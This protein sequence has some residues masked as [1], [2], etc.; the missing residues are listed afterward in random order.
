MRR[1][2]ELT[3]PFGSCFFRSLEQ[4]HQ[5][6]TER[7]GDSCYGSDAGPLGWEGV[8]VIWRG[9]GRWLCCI[10]SDV[11]K[12]QRGR[13][14][15][16]A[17]V[18]ACFV[19]EHRRRE[20]FELRHLPV[21]NTK[22]TKSQNKNKPS[23]RRRSSCFS[24]APYLWPTPRLDFSIELTSSSTHSFPFHLQPTLSP[25]EMSPR[26]ILSSIFSSSSRSLTR[27]GSLALRPSS[28]LTSFGS[29]LRS[30]SSSLLPTSSTSNSNSSNSSLSRR[31][32]SSHVPL[33]T[34]TTSTSKTSSSS[35]NPKQ[36]KEAEAEDEEEDDPSNP[37]L[38][39]NPSLSQRFKHLSKKYG[40]WAVGTYAVLG[41]FDF[42]IAF[43][44]V[45]LF[46]AEKV[47]VVERKVVGWG[48]E[49]LGWEMKE[50]SEEEKLSKHG[51]AGGIWTQ[52]A[53]VSKSDFYLFFLG[54]R[55]GGGG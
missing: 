1:T 7:K 29:T 20:L 6:A 25:P 22:T 5:G 24:T 34:S 16:R 53:V 27:G 17:C 13:E 14:N 8:A 10:F 43:V 54:G 44:G 2:R 12:S 3:F 38:P 4:G 35:S 51:G 41:C 46:G 50:L 40:W 49:Q 39:P 18:V 31:P 45:G 28:F 33:T 55:G 42:G 15:A 52:V 9:R 23:C 19:L 32:Y 21:R 11:E 47:A 26:S 37:P 36:E 48:Y 30:P